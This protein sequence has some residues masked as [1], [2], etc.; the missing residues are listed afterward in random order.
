MAQHPSENAQ[1]EANPSHNLNAQDKNL[2]LIEKQIEIVKREENKQ[3]EEKMKKEQKLTWEDKK[4]K[5][6]F[7]PPLPVY[8]PKIVV[9]HDDTVNFG[10]NMCFKKA[11]EFSDEP[12]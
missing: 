12:D 11:H 7:G 1:N 8:K 10:L 4:H 2:D 9:N 5:E 3:I 6:L